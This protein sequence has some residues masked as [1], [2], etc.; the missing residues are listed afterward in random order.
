[1]IPFAAP[2]IQEPVEAPDA[3][4][5]L[6]QARDLR[7]QKKWA[8]AVAVYSR[9]LATWKD[10][11]LALFERAQTL[12]WMKRFDESIR[13]FKRHREVYPELAEESEP[14]LAR[15][16]AWS[17]RFKEAVRILEPYVA[18]GDRQATLDTATFLSWDGQLNR[19][20]SM[21]GSWL[22]VHP[23]DRE[24]LILQGR[25]LGWRGKH[26]LARRAYEAVLTGSKGDRD[27]LLGLS[28]LDLWAG[29]PEAAEL[30]LAGLKAEDAR[31]PEAELM[32][33]QIDQRMGRLRSARTKA[34]SLKE[35]LDVRDDVQSRFRDLADAQG[36]WVEMSQTRTDSNDGL[37]AQSQHLDAAIPLWDG[38]LRLGGTFYLLDQAGQSERHP[39]EWSLGVNHPLGPR[40]SFAAQVGRVDDVGGSPASTHSLSLGARVAPGLNVALSQTLGPNLATPLAVDL[41]TITRTW[42]LDGSWVFNQTRDHLNWSLNRAFLSAGATV[43]VLRLD[44]GHRFPFEHGEW[45]AGFSGRIQDQNQS[46]NVG[47]FNPERY[48]YY[49]ATGGVSLSHE[50]RWEVTLDAWGGSQTVNQDPSQ[51]SWGYALAGNWRP[52]V[53]SPLTL[54]ASWGQSVA[55]LPITNTSDPSSYRDHTLRFGIKIRGNGWIW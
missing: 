22:S 45:R 21:T 16:T 18:K 48:R 43:N 5:L 49:G 19:S 47:F 3:E 30:R 2:A 10:H 35:N 38:S 9:M 50:E 1:M 39:Q 46:L 15:V 51:F 37:R 26:G 8:E 23:E 55:G 54:F 52:K 36:P 24:F 7:G 4:V 40:I 32:R 13:D 14:A 28:Q 29:D 34:E 6:E 17:K 42:G 27:A 11:Q 53:S 12:S 41:R 33:S 25:V 20:L 31:S 44:A